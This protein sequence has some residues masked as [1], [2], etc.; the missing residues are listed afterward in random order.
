MFPRQLDFRRLGIGTTIAYLTYAGLF[1]LFQRQVLYPGQYIKPPPGVEPGQDNP[2]VWWLDTGQGPVEAWFMPAPGASAANPAPAIIY[3]HGNGELIDDWPRELA[4]FLDLGIS[5]LLVE[6]PGYGRSS[7]S[8]SQRSITKTMLAAYDRL[9]ARPEVDSKRI[10]AQGR[11]LG[12]GAASIVA[13]NRPTAALILE[14]T[15]SSVRSF[16][17]NYGLPGF[18]MRDPFENDAVVR[19]YAGPILIIHGVEDTL[20]PLTHGQ[21]LAGL[22]SQ[23]TLITYQCGHND[24]PPDWAQYWRDM[25]TFLRQAR[26]IDD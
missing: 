4:R 11:S 15:F 10:I 24:C 9:A 23:A 13:A 6:Y 2:E 21:A 26:I 20:I 14:S 1:F 8:P 19:R 18:L 22:A 3:A 7:G 25:T 12:G 17:R 16:A 5:L